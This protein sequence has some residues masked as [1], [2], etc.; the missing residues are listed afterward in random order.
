M[1]NMLVP[2]IAK[3]QTDEA[4]GQTRLPHPHPSPA[5]GNQA[6]LRQLQAKLTIGAVDDPLEHEADAV[7]EQVMRMPDPSLTF[8]PSPPRISRKCAAC[9][10]EDE[11]TLQRQAA[12]PEPQG[13][14]PAAVHATLGSPGRPLDSAA[15]AFFEP[16]LGRDL[17]SVRIHNDAQA[18]VSARSVGASAYAVGSQ[19]VFGAGHYQPATDQGRRLIAH[20]LAHTV[21][22]SGGTLRRSVATPSPGDAAEVAGYINGFAPGLAVASGVNVTAAQGKCP[23]NTAPGTKCACTAL[24]DTSR[25]YNIAP[26]D[27]ALSM[28]S[29]TLA[30]KTTATIP[31]SSVWPNT[32][33]PPCGTPTD[34]VI[35]KAGSAMEFGFFDANSK[36]FWYATPRILAHEL[37]G[38][39][40]LC[41]TYT[42][43]N[44][45]QR[46][47][48]RPGH[49]P[50]IDTENAISG[51]PMRGHYTDV[52]RQGESFTNK[53][54]DRSKL[55][56]KLKDGWHYEAP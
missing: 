23:S 10:E 48:N 38:H 25:T 28:K 51:P 17:G 45:Q 41:Q 50:T 54:G 14:A 52:P 55:T 46:T 3:S 39:G 16:R 18:A 5:L 36:P 44:S 6:A 29:E 49:D 35:P 13:E 26:Q 20:E 21:Q 8:T 7:A 22:Q 34:I 24:Q 2:P 15:R 27:C 43:G 19:I 12:G 33:G 32:N 4:T 31:E 11:A 47:G 37:C 53:V 30:D 56:F 9:E 1:A 42:A 40:V